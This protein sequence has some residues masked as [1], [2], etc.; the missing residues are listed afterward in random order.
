MA[1]KVIRI[2]DCCEKEYEQALIIGKEQTEEYRVSFLCSSC[3]IAINQLEQLNNKDISCV[4]DIL[5]YL[6]N[7][8]GELARLTYQHDGDKISS[9]PKIQVW[10]EEYFGC[11]IHLIKNCENELCKSLKIFNDEKIP[12]TE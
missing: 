7:G 11:R 2:C 4:K 5:S 3:L 9:Y 6:Y 8:R 10:F 1:I 12:K